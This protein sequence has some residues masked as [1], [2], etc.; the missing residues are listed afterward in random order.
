MLIIIINS[1]RDRI[2]YW[3]S[4]SLALVLVQV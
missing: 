1:A 4:L 2:W 3:F